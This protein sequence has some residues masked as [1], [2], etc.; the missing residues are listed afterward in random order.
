M[1]YGRFIVLEG[2]D[3]AGTTRH[4]ELLAER[5]AKEMDKSPILTAEPTDGPIGT[6]VRSLLHGEHRPQADSTQLL[7]CADRAEHVASVI[8]PALSRGETVVC[9]RYT[10][11]TIIYGSA[12]GL[13]EQWLRSINVA[14]PVPDLTVI[15]LPPF[16]VCMERT[17]R[18]GVRDQFEQEDFQRGIYDAYA[19]LNEKNCV[20]VDTTGD[21][22]DVAEEVWQHVRPLL[23]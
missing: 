14:F 11:S 1:P 13:D 19:K 10:L 17:G 9:D 23:Q 15:T 6:M 2:P 7:F 16:E 5:I 8:L 12:Q 18:R 4:S 20:F 22:T 3:G 21:K